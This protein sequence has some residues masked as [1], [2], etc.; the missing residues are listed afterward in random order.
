MF[1]PCLINSAAIQGRSDDRPYICAGLALMLTAGNRIVPARG[2][3][4]CRSGKSWWAGYLADAKLV[5]AC[6]AAAS[7]I[8]IARARARRWWCWNPAWAPAPSTGALVQATLAR[9]TK[10]C[11]YDRAGYWKSPPSD[12]ARDAGAEADDLAALLKAAN[13]PHLM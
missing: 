13:S 4:L 8:F 6:R 3:I 10:V 11:A 12:D 2:G 7:S 1:S 9:T 5:P